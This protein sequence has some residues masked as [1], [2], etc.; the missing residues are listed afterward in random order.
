MKHY[1]APAINT[2]PLMALL[3]IL[4]TACQHDEDLP[5]LT[6]PEMQMVTIIGNSTSVMNFS[7]SLLFR[8][9]TDTGGL[10]FLSVETVSDSCK[11]VFNL[12]DGMYDETGL[13][14]DSLHLKTYTYTRQGAQT[15]GL[16]AVAVKN[17]NG[18]FSFLTTDSSSVTIRKM[19]FRTR[20]ISGSFYFVDNEKKINGAGTFENACYVSLQ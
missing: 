12:T 11:V 18:E 17:T 20:T 6:C 9:R 13:R 3:C 7:R 16:V 15:G 19:N 5:S 2:L 1:L 8:E 4:L 14:D 10:K